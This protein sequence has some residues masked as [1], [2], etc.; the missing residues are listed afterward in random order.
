MFWHASYPK[1]K[2]EFVGPMPNSSDIGINTSLFVVGYFH[3]HLG[4]LRHIV[5]SHRGI[6]PIFR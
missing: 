4:L 3:T 5:I 1:I 2:R 6:V